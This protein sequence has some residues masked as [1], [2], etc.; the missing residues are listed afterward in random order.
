MREFLPN[1][2]GTLI[3]K[4]GKLYPEANLLELKKLAVSDYE[5]F[6]LLVGVMCQYKDEFSNEE[7]NILRNKIIHGERNISSL[8]CNGL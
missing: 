5:K 4:F 2:V 1:N 7:I 8:I 6:F 3:D